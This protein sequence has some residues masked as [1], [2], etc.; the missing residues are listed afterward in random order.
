MAALYGRIVF[1]AG[2]IVA[3]DL[4]V[5]WATRQWVV[6]CRL[7]WDNKGVSLSRPSLMLFIKI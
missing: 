3:P 5:L 7:A 2:A 1:L 6:A 4:L